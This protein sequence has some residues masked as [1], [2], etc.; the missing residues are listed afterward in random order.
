MEQVPLSFLAFSVFCFFVFVVCF[1]LP[2]SPS[3]SSTVSV[4]YRLPL[5]PTVLFFRS[6]DIKTLPGYSSSSWGG[7]T[8]QGLIKPL[9]PQGDITCALCR[10]NETKRGSHLCLKHKNSKQPFKCWWEDGDMF[11]DIYPDKTLCSY[12]LCHHPARKNRARGEKRSKQTLQSR[13]GIVLEL[14]RLLK[15][16]M[17]CWNFLLIRASSSQL[18]SA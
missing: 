14:L 10:A 15:L 2:L 4:S 13:V 18:H 8:L 17:Q 7:S 5:S 3:L 11:S 12:C 6:T 1:F 9:T 16:S